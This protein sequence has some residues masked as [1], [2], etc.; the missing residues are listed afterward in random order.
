MYR[1][2]PVS[3][4]REGRTVRV[5]LR[6][7][8]PHLLVRY[9]VQSEMAD[10]VQKVHLQAVVLDNAASVDPDFDGFL[11]AFFTDLQRQLIKGGGN[12]SEGDETVFRDLG[13]RV[14]TFDEDLVG[15]DIAK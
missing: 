11:V 14:E 3:L 12:L 15:R 5:D 7:R 4:E 9:V 2:R 1:L 8:Y 6:E 13:H 10:R